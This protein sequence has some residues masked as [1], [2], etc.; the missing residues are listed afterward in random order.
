MH[1]RFWRRR[2]ALLGRERVGH[3]A[4]STGRH[5]DAAQLA[6]SQRRARGQLQRF[7]CDGLR[8]LSLASHREDLRDDEQR[9]G[10]LDRIGRLRCLVVK[11]IGPVDPSIAG[12]LL[13][14]R[15]HGIDRIAVVLVSG[16]VHLDFRHRQLV[17]VH[18]D[19]RHRQLVGVHLDFRH[20]H[21]AGVRLDFRR[22][23]TGVRLD[24]RR[25][26][27]GVRLD[28]RR[29]QLVGVRLDF[30]SRQLI[31]SLIGLRGRLIGLDQSGFGVQLGRG[32]LLF[33]HIIDL[34][35][36]RN[37]IAINRLG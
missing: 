16:S 11:P 17:G 15:H 1:L 10:A 23:L 5:Q 3:V 22:Q 14:Q 29:R 12:S 37:G 30:R 28:F 18:L 19:F 26:L 34:G 21:L 7:A 13:H 27:T 20:R 8:A 33:G 4:P 9:I 36:H 2:D 24:F 6:M 35:L 32:L 25:Q 31:G